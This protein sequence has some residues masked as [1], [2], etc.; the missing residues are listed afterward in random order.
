MKLP[1]LLC[2]CLALSACS[3]PAPTDTPEV[4]EP[5]A[6]AAADSAPRATELRDAM[7]APL[8]KARAAEAAQQ[9]KLEERD[10]AL[11]DAGG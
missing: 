9:E 5:Q 7:K 3:D 4:P 2:A 11:E 6:A 8:D 10:Q 1:L